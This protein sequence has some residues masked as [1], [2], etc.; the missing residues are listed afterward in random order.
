MITARPQ[1]FVE[2]GLLLLYHAKLPCQPA[3]V[4][5]FHALLNHAHLQ[6]G[7]DCLCFVT[8]PYSSQV[9]VK[10]HSLVLYMQWPGGKTLQNFCLSAT[11][12]SCNIACHTVCV[13]QRIDDNAAS[14]ALIA[15]ISNRVCWLC[16]L[17]LASTPRIASF[18]HVFLL[19]LCSFQ[20]FC[21]VCK[22]QL[23]PN[24]YQS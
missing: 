11:Y 2:C 18:H 24:V 16:P 3:E 9:Y 20:A 6:Q 15:F 1:V 17:V 8:P 12:G 21:N 4:G 10:P 13:L 5:C 22:S 19:G 7:I 23:W 14:N